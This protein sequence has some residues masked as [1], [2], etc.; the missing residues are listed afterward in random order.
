MVE[1]AYGTT[2]TNTC[3]TFTVGMQQ[4]DYDLDQQ[5]VFVGLPVPETDIIIR[6]F[7]TGEICVRSPSIL[8]SYW[9]KPDETA[10]AIRD[11]WLHTGDI[12]M[13]NER[14]FVHYFGRRKEMLKVN[15]MPVFPAEI[16]MLLGRHLA[17]LGSAVIGR[18][19]PNKGEVPVAFIH[20]DPE[21]A[22]GLD[23]DTLR[24][25]CRDHMASFK[26]PEIRLVDELPM[27]ITGKVKKEE[28][29]A[30]ISSRS[31]RNGPAY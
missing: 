18:S 6:D 3:D 5:P 27:T 10:H 9:N 4:N 21:Q 7:E 8:K 23:A 19:D 25:W 2:E 14:G 29:K 17:V 26:V 15:G 30:L 1:A 11:G 20:L 22:A 16:E 28:L 13:V 31:Y 12:G 24:A